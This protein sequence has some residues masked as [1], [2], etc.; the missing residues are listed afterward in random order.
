MPKVKR[1]VFVA[2]FDELVD[3]SLLV[4][5][6]E[7][8]EEHEWDGFFLWDHMRYLAPVR[9]IADPWVALSAI[10]A[11]TQRMRLG[12][13]VT[14]LPRR[15]VQKVARETASLD[16]LSG[17]RLVFGVGIGG[18]EA[19]EFSGFGDEPDDRRRAQLLDEGL[20]RLVELWNGEFQPV[21]VQ[22]PRVPVWVAAV[23][24]HR[25]PVARAARWDG[26]FPI[27]LPSPQALEELR[28][29]IRALR[30]SLE[31]FDLIAEIS[32]GE[33]VEPWARAGATWVLTAFSQTPGLDEVRAAIIAGP[34]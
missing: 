11:R 1:G 34:S 31:G 28:E 10:A 16:L 23:Y 12:P 2:P 14:P 27:Q 6:A 8:A 29:E 30:G 32:A 25:R 9:A 20:E 19:G 17:G 33:D 3:P 22:R 13:L 24:P 26:L 5:L 4:A 18:D 7:Q 21:P 15:R